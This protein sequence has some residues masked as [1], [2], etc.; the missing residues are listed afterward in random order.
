M[1]YGPLSSVVL[2]VV[3][4][5]LSHPV[6]LLSSVFHK[7]KTIHMLRYRKKHNAPLLCQAG[8]FMQAGRLG[9]FTPCTTVPSV[10]TNSSDEPCPPN[11]TSHRI[12]TALDHNS[13][14]LRL[15]QLV[16]VRRETAAGWWHRH[17]AQMVL[18]R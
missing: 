4:R 16:T 8:S 2:S 1:R 10:F 12:T 18:R 3:R 5:L 9:I 6:Y 17:C 11:S 13:S 14:Q 15:G 7:N